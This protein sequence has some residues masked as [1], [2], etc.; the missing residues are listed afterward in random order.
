VISSQCECRIVG[1]KEVE[2]REKTIS[3]RFVKARKI[4]EEK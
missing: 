3:K 1:G 2:G 4:P